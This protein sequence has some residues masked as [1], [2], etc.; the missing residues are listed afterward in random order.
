MELDFE[1]C[2]AAVRSKDARF[3]GYFFSGV[4]STGIY[5]RPSCPAIT[6]K[7]ANLTFHPT[8]AAAQQSGFRACKR[9]RPDASPGSAEWR[10]RGDVAARAMTLIA[11]GVVDRSGVT[12][13]AALLGYSPRQVQRI[14]VQDLGAEPIALARAQRAHTARLLIET[15]TL[16]MAQVA[17]ASGFSSVR[18]FNDTIGA[19]YASTPTQLRAARKGKNTPTSPGVVT[20]RLTYRQ[21]LHPVGLFGHLVATAIPGLESWDG[22]TYRRSLSLNF[23]D[24]LV[25]LTPRDGFI[26]CGLELEDLR[27]L[28]SAVARC[29]AMLDLD[30]DPVAIDDA[31]SAD[32]SMRRL[33]R[34][35]HGRRIPGT[36][37]PAEWAIRVVIGQQVSTAAARTHGERLVAALGRP[38]SRPRDGVTSTFPTA[39]R[40]SR[41]DDELLKMPTRRAGTVRAVA[42]ALASGDL[43]LEPGADR[44]AARHVLGA[45]PGIGPWT[46]S[47]VIMRGLGGPDEFL[48]SDLGV[49]VTGRHLKLGD[50]ARELTERAER[51]RP[52]R[53]YAVQYLWGA[54]DHAINTLPTT[55]EVTA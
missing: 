50:S 43:Q 42:S 19:I 26:Q 1:R 37:D 17:S 15:T 27:D 13:L 46:T 12:G 22:R 9:C 34:A 38:L 4:T 48:A 28:S 18:Q 35:G 21:P 51:W 2:Y 30:A 3:D 39:E 7:R 11:D 53:S 40:L 49:L 52:W 32:P 10:Y 31:L 54:G 16:P 6:P 29:R 45:M 41:A 55:K 23:G 25:E 47:Q 33:V 5:C 36:V 20:L 24:G 8:A 44:E 14:C